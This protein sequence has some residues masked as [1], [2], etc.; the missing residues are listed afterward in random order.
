[1]SRQAEEGEP[2]SGPGPVA[3]IAL[4]GTDACLNALQNLHNRLAGTEYREPRDNRRGRAD[5]KQEG[6]DGEAPPTRPSL[7]RKLAIGLLLL[8]VGGSAGG[9]FAW[10][11]L[12]LQL[13]EHAG[14]V[15]RMQDELD[16]M[17]KEDARNLKLLD[18]FQRE[19]AEYRHLAREAER[20][21]ETRQ[22]RVDALEAQ[23]EAAARAEEAKRAELA[24]RQAKRAAASAPR[25]GARAPQKTG[26]CAAGSAGDV[27]NC[28]EAFNR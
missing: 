16:A 20:D 27:S 28:I 14:V 4:R 22:R 25:A 9:W 18:K 7:L 2:Q 19:N 21:A 8:L 5:P 24:A 15:E 12:S 3:R 23:I 6:A 10:R 11:G 17:R 13:N 1:M 26:N